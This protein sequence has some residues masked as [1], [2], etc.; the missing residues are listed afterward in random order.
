MN[1]KQNLY[2]YY[3]DIHKEVYGVRPHWTHEQFD[4][5]S[6]EEFERRISRLENSFEA[7]DNYRTEQ[8]EAEKRAYE[9]YIFK[10]HAEEIEY[11]E[12]K[13]DDY[14]NSLAMTVKKRRQRDMLIA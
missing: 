8:L 14:F 9:E 7:E 5:A 6:I 10:A 3:S 2:N 4:A 11:I 12:R 13:E 1:K